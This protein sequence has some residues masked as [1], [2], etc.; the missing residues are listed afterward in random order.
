VL[1]VTPGEADPRTGDRPLVRQRQRQLRGLAIQHPIQHVVR[2]G[3]VHSSTPTRQG[4]SA[5]SAAA[6]RAAIRVVVLRVSYERDEKSQVAD[7][8]AATALPGKLEPGQGCFP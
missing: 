7:G 1:I 3:A 2:S 4:A 8:V 6:R 5:R